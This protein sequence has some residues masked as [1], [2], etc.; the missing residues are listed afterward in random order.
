[1]KSFIFLLK[2]ENRFH[3]FDLKYNINNKIK[4]EKYEK[5]NHVTVTRQLTIFCVACYSQKLT[6][7]HAIAV[8]VCVLKF[9]Y[10]LF[11]LL[12]NKFHS[13]KYYTISLETN[14]TKQMLFTIDKIKK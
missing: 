8:I 5:T 12:I 6:R 2:E 13:I 7:N 9:V 1:M 14:S 4:I 10:V 11:Y 3:S